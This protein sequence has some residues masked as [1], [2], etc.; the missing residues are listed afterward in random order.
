[1]INI[2]NKSGFSLIEVIIALG[3]FAI[4]AAGVFNVATSS[5]RNFYSTG[6][7]QSLTEYAQEGIEAVRAIRDNSWQDI[8]DASGSNH[9]LVKTNGYWQFSGTSDTF[10]D[11]TRV[12]TIS[13]VER[14]SSYEIVSSGGTDDPHTKKAVVTISGA[15]ISNYVLTTYLTNWLYKTWTQTDWSGVGDREYWS[16]FTMASSTYSSTTT[17]T[18]GQI[19]I[20][21]NSG[22]S[23]Y[24]T[25]SYIYSSIYS[26]DH[27]KE[28]QS[29]EVEQNIPAGCDVDVTL[30]AVNRTTGAVS[31]SQVFS[32]TS[33]SHYV[34]STPVSLNGFR[35][36]RYKLDLTPCSSNTQTPTVYSISV[37]YR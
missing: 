21:Y 29:I 25:D 3:I 27:D 31:A 12:V 17:S 22:M 34:S 37:N 33:S 36:F 26:L 2:V 10:G 35:F 30:E 24:D 1:M 8:E 14:N 5:Y 18:I 23:Q 20:F 15:G 9:G 13:D 4:L 32:D 28:L 6:D 19:S 11:L 7:K 16:D